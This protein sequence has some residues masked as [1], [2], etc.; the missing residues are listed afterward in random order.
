[1][2]CFLSAPN[3]P[4]PV[5][6]F[7][8]SVVVNLIARA[9]LI[10]VILHGPALAFEAPE[11]RPT[12]YAPPQN[13][14]FVRVDG[15]DWNTGRIASPLRTI[16]AA[17]RRASDGDTVVIGGGIYREALPV[18]TRK[19]TLQPFPGETVWIKGSVAVEGWV[20][21]GGIWI[22]EDWRDPFCADC[23]HPANID[24][25]FP[26]A[27]DPAQLFVDGKPLRQVG[28]LGEV[29]E[30]SFFVDRTSNRLAI[31]IDPGGRLV[32]AVVHENA[33]TVRAGGEGTR[34]RGLGF[35]QF[36][37]KA[38]PGLDGMV[39]GDAE[40]LVFEDNTF[41]FSA[42]KG[43]VIYK[44][45]ATVRGNVFLHNGMAGLSAW[46]ASALVVEGNRFA[47]NN[48]EQF[49]RM[50]IVAEASGAKITETSGL[51]VRDNVFELNAGNGLWLDINVID[52]AVTRNVF[53]GNERHGLYAELSARLAVGANICADNA[54]A[55][56]ALANT[57]DAVIFN[58][59][60]V[61]NR[62]GFLI[63]NDERMNLDPETVAQGS[64]WI[65]GN[66]RFF[67]NLLAAGN[68]QQ[69]AHIWV[70]D[71]AANLD[72][73]QML[74]ESGNNGFL[75]PSDTNP[76]H[77]SI[78]WNGNQENQI[79]DLSAFQAQ[80]GLEQDSQQ[81]IG[82]QD[83]SSGAETQSDLPDSQTPDWA[84]NAARPM[85]AE[86]TRQLGLNDIPGDIGSPILSR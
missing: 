15:S 46:Q 85:P 2:Y 48:R 4:G 33:L 78:W 83:G 57:A 1:M 6:R 18:I 81:H 74:T 59:T 77:F 54:S 50:G 36:S 19:L 45:N 44:P 67:N 16:S 76:S 37:Q 64:S 20:R 61:R 55:G 60:L 65:S 42:V 41:A 75:G 71:F 40:G 5:F 47:S 14:I 52:A 9:A 17:L 66:I 35:S 39:K 7:A 31:G 86:L 51:Q 38:V 53:R 43:L 25:Q 58:N 63:Q 32:E 11:V 70:R 69:L 12:S 22:R 72:A 80:T 3:R 68:E 56:I 84:R 62:I 82:L 73:E 27:G 79:R 21:E 23:F 34:I 30:G 29:D 28:D 8:R 49:A 13:A 10:C 24:P 26:L